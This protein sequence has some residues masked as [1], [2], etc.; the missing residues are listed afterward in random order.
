LVP[1]EKRCGIGRIL[2]RSN[3]ASQE[4][5]EE[6]EE[7]L[8]EDEEQEEE[9]EDEEDEEDDQDRDEDLGGED[10]EADHEVSFEQMEDIANDSA[11]TSPMFPVSPEVDRQKKRQRPEELIPPPPP[12][13]DEE[14]LPPPPPPVEDEEDDSFFDEDD[15]APNPSETKEQIERTRVLFVSGWKIKEIEKPMPRGTADKHYLKKFPRFFE[16]KRFATNGL[17]IRAAVEKVHR[18]GE[19]TGFYL[20]LNDQETRDM[21][22]QAILNGGGNAR[23]WTHRKSSPR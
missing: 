5:E 21:V 19:S 16:L 2:D 20:Q 8:E 15:V 12:P 4:E 3:R 18:L 11:P 13:L 1:T 6:D 9:E 14:S 10:E 17:D 7:E 22:L 23:V